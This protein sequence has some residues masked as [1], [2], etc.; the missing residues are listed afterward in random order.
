MNRVKIK[1]G[2][3][4]KFRWFLRFHGQHQGMSSIRGYWGRR[5]AEVAAVKAFG[6]P[7]IIETEDGELYAGARDFD[8]N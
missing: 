6:D 3:W 5:S 8:H 7:I 1:R 2:A 4:L